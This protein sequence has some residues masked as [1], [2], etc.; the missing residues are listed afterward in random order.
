METVSLEHK[1]GIHGCATCVMNYDAAE[2]Y[3]VGQPNQG[4]VC[5]FTMMN[6]ARIG[7]G[8]ES[9]AI[10]ERSYQQALAYAKDRIQGTTH[11]GVEESVLSIIPTSDVCCLQ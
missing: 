3:L 4:L 9:V 2:G 8:N 6:D 11:D 7:V 1:L 5:M 10:A